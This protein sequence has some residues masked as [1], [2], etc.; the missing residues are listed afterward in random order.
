M[1]RTVKGTRLY[2]GITEVQS[3]GTLKATMAHVD[4]AETDA[5]KAYRKAVKQLGYNFTVIK[6]ETFETLYV[7]DDAIFFEFAKPV[8][9]ETENE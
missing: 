2:Y 8:K 3:D 4:V 9:P 5:K 1:Q 7:L 6:S